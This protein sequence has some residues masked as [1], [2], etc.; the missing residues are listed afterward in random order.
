MGTMSSPI[1]GLPQGVW[2]G[3]E[4][5]VAL[6][7]PQAKGVFNDLCHNDAPLIFVCRFQ[8]DFSRSVR[9]SVSSA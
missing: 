4:V 8:Y 5:S 1:K 9:I 3:G 6:M 7:G 2:V